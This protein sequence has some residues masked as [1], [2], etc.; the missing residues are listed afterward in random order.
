MT[1]SKKAAEARAM[2]EREEH[3]D[4]VRK[5]HATLCARILMYRPHWN[6]T[7]LEA[8]TFSWGKGGLIEIFDAVVAADA[9][10]ARF[11]S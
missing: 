2:R 4:R 7:A 10:E 3:N 1:T 9:L 11:K 6:R 5:E 8:V